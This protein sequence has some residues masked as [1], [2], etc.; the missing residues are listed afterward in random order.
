VLTVTAPPTSTTFATFALAEIDFHVGPYLDPI[1]HGALVTPSAL[2]GVINIT[3]SFNAY[4]NTRAYAKGDY[5]TSVAINYRSLVDA[6]VGNTPAGAPSKWVAVSAGEVVG[7]NGFQT[8]DI[9]R[10]IRLYSEP[11]IW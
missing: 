11:Q 6:N 7:P 10:L 5:V 4:D 2:I 9:G 1:D 3:I 8:S